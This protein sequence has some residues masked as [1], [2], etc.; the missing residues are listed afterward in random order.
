MENNMQQSANK[1]LEG[2]EGMIAELPKQMAGLEGMLKGNPAAAKEYATL[3]KS[4]DLHS[5]ITALKKD[6]KKI[7]NTFKT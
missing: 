6:L 5:K 7:N 2:L 3:L 1:M 4:S